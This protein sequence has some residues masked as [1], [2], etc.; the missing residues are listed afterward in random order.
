[1]ATG[2]ERGAITPLG[3]TSPWPVIADATVAAMGSVAIGGG[4]HGVNVHMRADDLLAVSGAEVAD[5][6][7]AAELDQG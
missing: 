2:Y 7:R 3:A 4:E 1:M 5:V 6:T